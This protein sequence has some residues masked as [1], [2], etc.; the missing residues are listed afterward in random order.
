LFSEW[1]DRVRTIIPPGAE[2]YLVGGAV[3]DALLGRVSHDLDFALPGDAPRVARRVANALG[4]AYYLLD[5]E[6][7][8]GR[9]VLNDEHG[10]VILDF[11]RFR[12]TDLLADLRARDFTINA[13]AVSMGSPSE[14]IDPLGGAADL[15]ARRLR[16]CSAES[17]EED[18]LRLLRAV[19][20]AQ[21]FGLH[22]ERETRSAMRQAA[23]RLAKVSAE[24][25]RD[26][27]FKIL[28]G[29]FPED[30]LRRLVNTGIAATVFPL[31]GAGAER[32]RSTAWRA[33]ID[34]LDHIDQV[35]MMPREINQAKPD[36]WMAKLADFLDG[37]LI[38]P[39][40]LAGLLGLIAVYQGYAAGS[41]QYPS[42][43][44][45]KVRADRIE[46]IGRALALG[47]VEIQRWQRADRAYTWIDRRAREGGQVSPR[48]IY[49]YFQS[50]GPAGVDG[51]LL[52]LA[53]GLD[54]D[55]DYMENV[56]Q[57]Y[58]QLFEAW[59]DRRDELIYPPQWVDG[60]DLQRE[61]GVRPGPQIGLLLAEIGES[62]AEGLVR[63]REGALA[64]ARRC[65]TEQMHNK[66]GESDANSR[67]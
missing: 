49:R 22:I 38:P 67:Q 55:P 41:G 66:V 33:A 61:L 40:G 47:Q 5:G 30:G 17:I 65:L 29:P 1:F 14:L 48:Q 4:G 50:A 53:A 18:P 59:W 32:P 46:K 42:A 34:R 20:L 3:R 10:A 35:L 64:L 25:R 60:N 8:T 28:E 31:I 52:A 58:R 24:R 15:A 51:C 54:A 62:Q 19:R 21:Q 7:G 43:L 63:D 45:E 26:E 23:P 12:G 13:M 39:R 6:R 11:A 57:V 37:Q 44:G 56:G 36:E 16:M 2:V 9:V 27:L